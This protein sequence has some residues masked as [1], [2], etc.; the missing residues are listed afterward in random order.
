M[1]EQNLNAPSL[2]GTHQGNLLNAAVRR[3]I[4]DLNRLF[5]SHA[6]DPVHRDDPWFQLPAATIQQFERAPPEAVER[7]V[8]V[9]ITLFELVVPQPGE[10]SV[11]HGGAVGDAE[12]HADE[13]IRGEVRRSFGLIVLGVARRLAEGVP[14]AARIA[15]GLAPTS[16]TRLAALTPSDAFRLASWHGLVR[17]RWPDHA[18]FWSMLAGAAVGSAK[19]DLHW[20]YSAGLCLLGQCD[21][22]PPKARSGAPAR[23]TRTAH[24]RARP[25]TPDVPC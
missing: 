20:A 18:R 22:D 15:F 9:P 24:R 4:A 10:P 13:A 19:D 7:A 21:R 1:S 23:P 5:L 17:P 6:L 2:N 8:A 25:K 12:R 3:D 11:G 16:E 14:L